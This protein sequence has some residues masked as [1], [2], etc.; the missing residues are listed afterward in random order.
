MQKILDEGLIL[1]PAKMDTPRARVELLAITRQEDPEQHRRQV[2]KKNGQFV[3]EGPAAGLFQFERGGGVKG[4]MT[5]EAS[6][7]FALAVCNTLGVRFDAQAI[8]EALPTNDALAVAFARLLLWTD[9][10]PLP[11]ISDV[12]RAWDMYLR[13]WRPGA[14]TNGTEDERRKLL[15]KW[16]A[17]HAWARA[18]AGA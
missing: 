5:H 14:W 6:R 16:G 8:W 18:N 12:T 9:P 3:K 10:R 1:L 4:V 13:N 17:S 7:G 11:D 2:I 15:Q